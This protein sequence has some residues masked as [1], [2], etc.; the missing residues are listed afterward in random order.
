MAGRV[1]A[2]AIAGLLMGLRGKGESAEEIAGAVRAL[3]GAM[4][5]VKHPQPHRLVD[6]CGTGGGKVTT[7]N[8]STAAAFVAAGAGVPIAKHGNRSFTSRSGSADVL[9]ALGVAIDADPERAAEILAEAQIVFLFAPAYHPAMRHVGPV[10]AELG[11]ATLMNLIGPLANPAGVSRQV[12]GVSDP[13]KAPRVA[14]ALARL[15]SEHALVVHADVGMDEI[16]PMGLSTA[17]EVAN[18]A[19]R[20][21]RIDPAELGQ[22]TDSLEGLSGGSAAENAERIEALLATPATAPAALRAA[23]VLNAAAAVLVS[24]LARSMA[25]AASRAA[26]ALNDGSAYAR[27]NALRRA[28]PR[29]QAP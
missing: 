3:R 24:G 11:A 13:A 7:I 17:W 10:R 22:A 14:E 5:T 23:V 9:E 4:R 18:G 12:V 8:I 25:D 28:A 26:G 29:R 2:V 16:S 15:G 20:E 21:W 1:S 19:V 27:L 6:T